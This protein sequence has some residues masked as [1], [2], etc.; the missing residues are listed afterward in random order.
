LIAGAGGKGQ[1]QCGCHQQ[2][3]DFFHGIPPWNEVNILVSRGQKCPLGQILQFLS[4]GSI[5]STAPLGK[6][7][8]ASPSFCQ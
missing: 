7:A 6:G 5:A 1:K 8:F 2:A 4:L 3:N